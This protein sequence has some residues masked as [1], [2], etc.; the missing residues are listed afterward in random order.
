MRFANP[1]LIFIFAI[2]LALP[3]QAARV[4]NYGNGPTANKNDVF[5]KFAPMNDDEFRKKM[6]DIDDL[7]RAGQ[8][9]GNNDW[10]RVANGGNLDRQNQRME[11]F[12]DLNVNQFGGNNLGGGK[13]DVVKIVEKKVIRNGQ[14]YY[15]KV[16]MVNGKVVEE[17]RTPPKEDDTQKYLD[18]ANELQK[19]YGIFDQREPVVQPKIEKVEA[20]K[21]IPEY[22]PYKPS[23]KIEVNPVVNRP[24]IDPKKEKLPTPDKGKVGLVNALQNDYG[25]KPAEK[26]EQ[27]YRPIF[28][29]N[30]EVVNVM[31]KEVPVQKGVEEIQGPV[32]GREVKPILDQGDIA[33]D[34]PKKPNI[35]PEKKDPGLLKPIVPQFNAQKPV[36]TGDSLT[37]RLNRQGVKLNAPPGKPDLVKKVNPILPGRQDRKGDLEGANMNPTLA[38]PG[39]SPEGFVPLNIKWEL[40]PAKE[41]CRK[42]GRM[43]LYTHLKRLLFK[44]SGIIRMYVFVPSTAPNRVAVRSGNVCPE[45]YV[46][47]DTVYGAHLVMLSRIYDAGENDETTIAKSSACERDSNSDDR[48]IV[49]RIAFNSFKMVMPTDNYQEQDD[50][51]STIVHETMHTLAFNDDAK[52]L[53]INKKVSPLK[54]HLT[55]IKQIRPEIY[56]SGHWAEAYIPNDIMTPISRSG[57]IMSVF[58][59]E[60]LEQRSSNYMTSTKKLPYDLFFDDVQSEEDFFRY[61]C[62]ASDK[63]SKYRFFCS[64]RQLNEQ[65]SGC[66]ID[67][68]FVTQCS[69]TRMENN[70]FRSYSRTDLNCQDTITEGLNDHALFEHRGTDSRCFETVDN[71]RG[72][73]LKFKVA[74][75]TVNV[76]LGS[77]TYPCKK[78]FEEIQGEYPLGGGR[79]ILVNFRC[80]NIDEFIKYATQT[81][82]PDNCNRNG[83][84]SKG[85]C[86]CF[87]GFD[88]ASNCARDSDIQTNDNLFSENTSIVLQVKNAGE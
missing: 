54:K 69:T 46:P 59:L 18:K 16:K 35:I 31:P 57:N 76:V 74:S 63:R 49:G 15:E 12:N 52:V 56:A 62:K 11:M 82:C 66:S 33:K 65:I 50:Y 44:A 45:Y 48:A 32:V 53:L 10:N 88:S 61:K 4:P 26:T 20:F 80:P 6:Q 37:D 39:D 5:G 14:V 2:S 81:S 38:R 70:C 9:Y 79:I 27:V 24:V 73:C 43:E 67:Y 68:N 23:P 85:K 41:Y 1:T 87:D 84:C 8:K 3:R 51:L 77:N 21:G 25:K 78:S 42:R 22:Q 60:L 58:S 7:I 36:A 34:V 28:P 29:K 17:Q 83:F 19:K 64:E 55:L 75:G 71:S 86:I 13:G 30:N 47:R 40:G 72:V